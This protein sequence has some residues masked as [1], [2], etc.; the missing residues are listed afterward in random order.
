[1]H[2]NLLNGLG[3]VAAT[4]FGATSLASCAAPPAQT[5]TINVEVPGS[6]HASAKRGETAVEG[7]NSGTGVSDKPVVGI[8]EN[9][10]AD[11]PT[12]DAPTADAPAAKAAP[13][14][15]PAAKPASPNKSKGDNKSE[16]MWYYD[17]VPAEYFAAF[18][19]ANRRS[20]LNRKGAIVDYAHNFIEI[21]GSANERDGDL[22]KLQITLFPNGKEPW[23]AASRIVWP[24]GQT[25]GKL[26]FYNNSA[27]GPGLRQSS[28]D[29]FPYRL[30]RV[31]GAY[32]SAWLPQRG[33]D[34][35]IN[36]AQDSESNGPRFHYNRDYSASKPAFSQVYEGEE[37]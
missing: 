3:A 32:Q 15:K 19:G 31:E 8:D 9:P 28:D 26:G 6:T 2:K 22:H 18:G 14:L 5:T 37:G 23:C 36:S 21:P 34:V 35:V 27:D 16:L 10:R 4:I 1:M 24:R 30:R 25:P 20:L 17:R 33:L 13:A 29:F 11:A 7:D 12:A